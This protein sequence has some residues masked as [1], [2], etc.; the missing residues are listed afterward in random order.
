MWL[1]TLD[2]QLAEFCPPE[3]FS[4]ISIARGYRY[5]EA[6]EAAAGSTISGDPYHGSRFGVSLKRV[7]RVRRTIFYAESLTSLSG[8]MQSA[9]GKL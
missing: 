6:L 3:R 8:N 9:F 1:A 7:V 2:A 5:Q 4:Q